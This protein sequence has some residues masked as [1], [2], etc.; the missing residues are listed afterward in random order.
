M[1]EPGLVREE[2]TGAGTRAVAAPGAG[3]PRMPGW[4]DRGRTVGLVL[5][6]AALLL[7]LVGPWAWGRFGDL[8]PEGRRIRAL[9]AR[10]AV[11][12]G[13]TGT[14]LQL[15]RLYESK[16]FYGRARALLERARSRFPQDPS[17]R[18]ALAEVLLLEKRHRAS[19]LEAR[20][21]LAASPDDGLAYY[22]LGLGYG[23]EGKWEEAVAAL[24]RAT[25]YWPSSPVVL[26]SLSVALA[27]V[28]RDKEAEAVR[29]QA[30]LLRLE[31]DRARS[32]GRGDERGTYALQSAFQ[33]ASW[34][35]HSD[36][37]IGAGDGDERR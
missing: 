13:E 8:S 24:K 11:R 30:E 3:V 21:A 16:G 15:A 5:W 37:G 25:T 6:T 27:K 22:L 33:S 34:T 29:R 32:P 35:R 36:S 1:E 17:V 20:A 10:L 28:G 19:I 4:G 18:T 31:R 9:E 2:G 26:E 7:L 14:Y 12:P 23:E